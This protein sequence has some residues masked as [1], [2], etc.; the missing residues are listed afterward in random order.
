M[1]RIELN[2]TDGSGSDGRFEAS[3]DGPG[4]ECVI[5]R[6]ANCVIRIADDMAADRHCRLYISDDQVFVENLDD[7]IGTCLNGDFVAEPMAVE[8]GAEL[9]VGATA[10]RVRLKSEF[11]TTDAPADRSV[12]LE[13]ESVADADEAP[14]SPEVTPSSDGEIDTDDDSTSSGLIMSQEDAVSSSSSGSSSGSSTSARTRDES[15]WPERGHIPP[16]TGLEPSGTEE[17]SPEEQQL[18]AA[19]DA[20]VDL[21]GTHEPSSDASSVS[22]SGTSRSWGRRV[23]YGAEGDLVDRIEVDLREEFPEETGSKDA[24]QLR[25]LIAR[26]V[27]RARGHGL[28]EDAH[29][30]QLLRCMIMLDDELDGR[31]PDTED[32][33]LTLGHA[34]RSPTQ[35]IDRAVKIATRLASERTGS[36]SARPASRW[37]TP[38]APV[39]PPPS[40]AAP[41]PSLAALSDADETAAD[42]SAAT[43]ATRGT[44]PPPPDA[45]EGAD[46]MPDISGFT[47]KEEIGAG[48]MGRVFLAH[49]HQLDKDVAIKVLRSVDPEAQEL[50]QQEARAAARLEHP[51]IVQVYQFERLGRGGYFVMQF[52]RGMD[53]SKVIKAF[54]SAG[55]HQLRGDQILETARVDPRRSPAELRELVGHD[56]TPYYLLVA[57]WIAGVA[58][59]LERAH[60]EGVL[61]RDI[62]P[63]N[64]LMSEDGRMMITDFGLATKPADRQGNGRARVGTPRYLS[65]ERVADWASFSDE[66]QAG[67][68]RA[69]IWSLGAVLY[70]FLCYRPA[71]KGTVAE[72]LRGITTE[73]PQAPATLVWSVPES[74]GA[75]CLKAMARR[76]DDR[77]NRCSD[78]A[79]SL[80]GWIRVESGL[81]KKGRIPFLP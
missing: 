71:Y 78:M 6:A 44:P 15:M 67:D 65:P 8:D 16:A 22:D 2:T 23:T 36:K 31:N 12:L 52:V 10:L 39:A 24:D 51:N 4:S 60:V 26:G 77:F 11:S 80:R 68:A 5:G 40:I 1:I 3:L 73:E 75:I 58:D 63:S 27:E 34:R 20:Q 41:D 46:V 33:W 70:E 53:G 74:L 42:L 72:V 59:G 69:D 61:H 55:T 45:S 9:L 35:R 18:A 38:A 25:A 81:D 50:L 48:G 62:K 43:H 47:L 14:A 21:S 49:D 13:T 76:P 30:Y 32:V 7:E 64:L 37:S 19:D 28:E 79:E 57:S 29:V 54:E 17:V 56:K 66:V